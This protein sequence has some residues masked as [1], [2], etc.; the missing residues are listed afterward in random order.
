MKL[1][2]CMY[3]L[4]YRIVLF[5][6]F[7]N[8]QSKDRAVFVEVWDWDAVGRGINESLFNNSYFIC[9]DDFLGQ[10]LIPLEQLDQ[11]LFELQKYTLVGKKENTVERGSISSLSLFRSAFF[12]YQ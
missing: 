2:L 7:S 11:G 1:L 8:L 9:T 6:F 10:I 4:Y 5:I 3:R 12:H